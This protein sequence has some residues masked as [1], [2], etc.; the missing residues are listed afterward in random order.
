MVE[1]F[2]TLNEEPCEYPAKIADLLARRDA[3]GLVARLVQ[4]R[5]DNEQSA[6]IRALITLGS[7]SVPLLL[8]ALQNTQ[9]QALERVVEALGQ[10]GDQRVVAPLIDLLIRTAGEENFF[11]GLINEPLL[12]RIERALT[13]LGALAVEP[14][15]PLLQHPAEKVRQTAATAL[16]Q[17]GDPRAL[18]ALMF[19]LGDA[20]WYVRQQA[21]LGLGRIG[22]ERAVEALIHALGD[23]DPL[24]RRA[25]TEALGNFAPEESLQWLVRMLK[26]GVYEVRLAAAQALS[27]LQDPAVVDAMLNALAEDETEILLLVIQ[28]LTRFRD[29]RT[30][31]GLTR[32]LQHHDSQIRQTAAHALAALGWQPTTNDEQFWYALARQAWDEWIPLATRRLDVTIFLLADRDLQTRQAA[33]EALRG[34]GA[35]AVPA[36]IEAC[37]QTRLRETVARL[38]GEIGDARAIPTLMDLLKDTRSLTLRLAAV[39]ALAQTKKAEAVPPLIEALYDDE[40]EVARKAAQ[41]LVALYWAG[42][43]PEETKRLILQQ[44]EFIT[45]HQ[46]TMGQNEFGCRRHEDQGLGVLFPL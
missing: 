21:A 20:S 7:E 28:A 42:R 12:H 40:L 15:L 35:V 18:D 5:H 25:A 30:V 19:A 26:D 11:A 23:K 45:A 4:T 43:L 27:R 10:T 22:D 39:E 36:L 14:L 17:I 24:V 29:R 2:E 3:Q 38:L 34:L 32:S 44:R 1:R 9:G 31:E 37:Q 8:E 6:I 33:Y 13:N 41:M 16:A 46:D